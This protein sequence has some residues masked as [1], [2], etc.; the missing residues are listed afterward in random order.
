M[1]LDNTMIPTVLLNPH[2]FAHIGSGCQS[3]GA[4]TWLTS[5]TSELLSDRR[6]SLGELHPEVGVLQ[7]EEESGRWRRDTHIRHRIA[8]V[9][10]CQKICNG[11][12]IKKQKTKM[13]QPNVNINNQKTLCRYT[14]KCFCSVFDIWRSTA[15]TQQRVWS[16]TDELLY[17]PLESGLRNCTCTLNTGKGKRQWHKNKQKTSNNASFLV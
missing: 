2:Q 7:L 1:Y 9:I 11:K 4:C 13:W 16:R 8:N 6:L 14:T 15:L 3:S 12:Y 5:L 17:F 10:V